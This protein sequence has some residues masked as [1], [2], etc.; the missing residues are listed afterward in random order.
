MPAVAQ[1]RRPPVAEAALGQRG[2]AAPM[3]RLQAAVCLGGRHLAVAGMWQHSQGAT[4]DGPA[5]WN[6][7]LFLKSPAGRITRP[8]VRQKS[9]RGLS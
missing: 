7:R 5:A 9:G 4:L 8:Q 6:S 1:S 3:C 2:Q